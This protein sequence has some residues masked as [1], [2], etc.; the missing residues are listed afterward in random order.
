[1]RP[2][3]VTPS[4]RLHCRRDAGHMAHVWCHHAVSLKGVIMTEQ[5]EKSE[6][7]FAVDTRVLAPDHVAV[8]R[9]LWD[10]RRVEISSS[11]GGRD[12]A[13]TLRAEPSEEVP[14]AEIS[15]A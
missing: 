3:E 14:L 9:C 5:S 2:S 8:I 7:V 6:T 15:A 10:E 4:G 13:Q 11:A 12:A 1:M